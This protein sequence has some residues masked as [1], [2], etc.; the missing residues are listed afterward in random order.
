M[1]SGNPDALVTSNHGPQRRSLSLIVRLEFAMWCPY[2]DKEID[3]SESNPEHI[4]PLALGGCKA[5]TIPVARSANSTIGSEIDGALTNDPLIAFARREFD[6]RGHS[7]TQPKVISKRATFRDR[8]AQVT[9]P[10]GGRAPVIWDAK[11]RQDVSPEQVEGQQFNVQWSIPRF[12]RIRFTAKVA[13]SAG[14]YALG[15]YFREHVAHGEARRIMYSASYED[16]KAIAS[17]VRTRVHDPFIPISEECRNLY[18]VISFLCA[19][20]HGSVVLILPGP[21][22]L[23]ISVGVLGNYVGTLNMPA[24]TSAFP[25]RPDYELGHCLVVVDRQLE[26]LSF[27]DY[28][29]KLHSSTPWSDL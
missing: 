22:N 8:P 1:R 6:A 13:L 17:H 7:G 20:L 5:F 16:F 18:S 19:R 14:F 9:F 23:G 25:D 29:A 11:S 24:G 12:S 10:G 21:T 28:L 27:R 2:T 15:D 3:E 4:L 26:R